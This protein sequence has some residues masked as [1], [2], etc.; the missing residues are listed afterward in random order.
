MFRK[1]VLKDSVLP[2]L[3]ELIN[4]EESSKEYGYE[5]AIRNHIGNIFLWILRNW[6]AQGLT[7][8]PQSTLNPETIERLEKVFEYVEQ[9]YEDQIP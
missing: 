6:N 5:L 9:H 4:R 8:G 3:I 1:S 7:V 2:L